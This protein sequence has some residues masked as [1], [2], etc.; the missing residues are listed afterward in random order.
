MPD[1]NNEDIDN[2]IDALKEKN[3]QLNREIRK[4]SKENIEDFVVDSAGTVINECV[5]LVKNLGVYLH[6]APESKDLSAYAELINA[7][8]NAIETLNK[9]LIQDK[10]STSAKEL[11]KMDHDMKKDLLGDAK[12]M[13]VLSRED[14]FK[15]IKEV[16]A[17]VIDEVGN[18]EAK[19]YNT[20]LNNTSANLPNS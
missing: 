6:A 9:I 2:I 18:D 7:S 17:V 3:I 13:L 15:Q 20:F 5:D 12:E 11:K 4:V 8:A 10:K 1:N 19:N 14:M 16:E